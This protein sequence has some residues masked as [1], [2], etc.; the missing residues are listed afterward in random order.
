MARIS[1]DRL[2]DFIARFAREPLLSD[3]LEAASLLSR[4]NQVMRRI[5][6]EQLPQDVEAVLAQS[7]RIVRDRLPELLPDPRFCPDC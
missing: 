3:Y 1:T 2:A 5:K 7:R 4:L 6:L